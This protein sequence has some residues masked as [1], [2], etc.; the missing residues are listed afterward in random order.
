MSGIASERPSSDQ[1]EDPAALASKTR[2]VNF[3]EALR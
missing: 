3:K 2:D 1:G